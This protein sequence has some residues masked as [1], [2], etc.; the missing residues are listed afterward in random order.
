MKSSNLILAMALT[1]ANVLSASA[2]EAGLAPTKNAQTGYPAYKNFLCSGFAQ[3]MVPSIK[4]TCLGLVADKNNG[5]KMPRYSVQAADGTIYVSDM[6]GWTFTGG[7]IWAIDL[8]KIGEANKKIKITN[9]FP[10]FNLTMPNGL[11][12]DP[13]GRLYVGMPTGIMRF[14]PKYTNGQFNIAASLEMIEN[15]FMTSLFRKNEYESAKKYSETDRAFKNSHPLIQLAANQDF[16]EIYMNVGAPSDNCARGVK[17][18]NEQGFCTQAESPLVNAG[19][20]KT[21]L[22]NNAARIKIKTS[23]VARGLRNS[24]GLAVHP[25]TQKLYQ[26]E[27]S[28]DL[29]DAEIPFEEINIIE[30]GQHYGWPYCHSNDQVNVAF[31]D[32]VKPGD[33]TTKYKSALINM[34]AHTA[35]LGLLFYQSKHLSALTGKLL[36]SWHGYRE[37]GQKV[38]AYS[39]DEKGLPI[40]FKAEPIISQWAAKNGVRPQGAPVGLTELNDGRL[41]VVDDKNKSLLILDGGQNYVDNA[42]DETKLIVTAEQIEAI[43]PLQGILNN[44]CKVCHSPLGETDPKK[45]IETLLTNTMVNKDDLQKS[46]LLL[47]IIKK[48]MPLGQPLDSATYEETVK[49]VQQFLKT[50]G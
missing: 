15:G 32:V 38:V 11:L 13:E 24:M 44:S 27:N 19:I 10:N 5:L 30:Q 9:L 34:P 39:L 7:T 8:P 45:L 29:K 50:L 31:T 49:A 47:R 12:I 6:S 1:F 23:P 43:K 48:E 22:S 16:T 36:V 21:T 2:L 46:K 18:K 40:S 14:Q 25:L 17:T 35:P 20:W 28:M 42:D 3:V 41:L 26:A 37:H 4:N 33:C